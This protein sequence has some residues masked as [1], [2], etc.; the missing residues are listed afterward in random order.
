LKV[1]G[2]MVLI[3]PYTDLVKALL[4]ANKELTALYKELPKDIWAD[5]NKSSKKA[6]SMKDIMELAEKDI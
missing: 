5:E 3:E 1:G 2:E 6:L 4:A